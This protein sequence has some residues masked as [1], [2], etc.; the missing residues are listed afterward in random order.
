MPAPK[1][2]APATTDPGLIN[3]K[4]TEPGITELGIT[5]L[6]TGA[7]TPPATDADTDVRIGVKTGAIMDANKGN[8]EIIIAK[9]TA[10]IS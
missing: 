6:T 1:M 9:S 2:P 7:N 4:I 3:P 8:C 10:S 5:K